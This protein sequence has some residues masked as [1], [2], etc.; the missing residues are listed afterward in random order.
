MNQLSQGS[1]RGRARRIGMFLP[2]LFAVIS[3]GLLLPACSSTP[4]PPTQQISA[5]EQ[6]LVDAEQ[7]RVAEYALPEMQEARAK[8]ASARAAV[9]SEDMV[10]A[11]RL[12]EQ[13]SVNIK[14]AAAKAELAKEK[15]VNE[16][17]KK[18]IHVLK[19][20]MNRKTG[21]PQ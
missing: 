1:N 11:K 6:A 21:G 5:A 3:L 16:D 8:L 9:K 20:E 17:M 10:L 15:A 14:L 18:N 2:H 19:Q 4:L 13:A 12:A 7:T